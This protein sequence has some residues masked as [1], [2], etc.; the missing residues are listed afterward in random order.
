MPGLGRLYG[1]GF[2]VCDGGR[3]WRRAM[4]PLCLGVGADDGDAAVWRFYCGIFQLAD[5]VVIAATVP[6]APLPDQG[7]YCLSVLDD[8]RVVRP[9]VRAGER[10]SCRH[11]GVNGYF[12]PA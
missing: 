5:R 12:S 2:R 7:F 3:D 9:A 4:L 11:N 6:A 1:A 8:Y 10:L